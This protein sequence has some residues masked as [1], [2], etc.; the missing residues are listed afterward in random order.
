MTGLLLLSLVGLASAAWW[1]FLKGRERARAAAAQVCRDHDL[2]L[3]DDTVVLDS[4][5][6]TRRRGGTGLRYRFEFAHHGRLSGGGSVL[7]RPQGQTTVVIQTL[8]G[9][10]IQEYPRLTASPGGS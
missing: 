10:V 9:Q 4:V 7:V 2:L 8:D 6:I 3:M 5:E 1:Q